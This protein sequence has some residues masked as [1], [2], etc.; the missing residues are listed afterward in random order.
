MNIRT[1]PISPP[2]VLPSEALVTIDIAVAA[3]VPLL[4][5]R[6]GVGFSDARG[7][8]AFAVASWL[9]P[10]YLPPIMDDR[11][12]RFQFEMPP[13]I[14][15]R[16]ALDVDLYDAASDAREEFYAATMIDVPDTNYLQMQ[17]PTTPEMGRL[18]V[19][20]TVSIV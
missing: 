8:R 17:E 15:G 1:E 16:Y 9:G 18:C 13:V 7:E 20:S 4:S 3:R 11:I 2:G 5:P 14:P 12:V 19:R 6:V 10:Q